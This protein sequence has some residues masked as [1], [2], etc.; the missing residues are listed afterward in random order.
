[1]LICSNCKTEIYS[2]KQEYCNLC[3]TKIIRKEIDN[4]KSEVNKKVDKIE[5]ILKDKDLDK[6]QINRFI[7]DLIQYEKKLQSFLHLNNK[8]LEKI[9]FV[10]FAC[11]RRLHDYQKLYESA[12]SYWQCLLTKLGK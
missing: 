5:K 9:Y 10:Q 4:L 1:M 6:E 11:Y 3:S 2:S 7:I 12:L 8:N